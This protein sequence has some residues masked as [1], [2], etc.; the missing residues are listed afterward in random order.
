MMPIDFATRTN[1]DE[2]TIQQMRRTAYMS[3]YEDAFDL[4]GCGVVSNPYPEGGADLAA[5]WADGFRDGR[6]DIESYCRH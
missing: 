2:E 4:H 6:R 3:G 1:P 5:Q